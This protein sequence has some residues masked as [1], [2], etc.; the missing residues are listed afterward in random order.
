MRVLR[1]VL[2]G[3]SILSV[4]VVVSTGCAERPGTKKEDKKDDKKDDKAKKDDKEKKAEEK[5]K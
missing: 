2:L 4:G 5:K 3:A 1:S